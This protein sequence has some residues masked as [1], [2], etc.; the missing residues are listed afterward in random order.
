MVQSR[1]R[2][3]KGRSTRYEDRKYSRRGRVPIAVR[4]LIAH[5]STRGLGPDEIGERRC[6]IVVV[7]YVIIQSS[8]SP[9]ML[10]EEEY[11]KQL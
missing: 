2:T 1:L 7:E 4:V 11:E 8:R 3:I 5:T 9:A 10:K 6:N